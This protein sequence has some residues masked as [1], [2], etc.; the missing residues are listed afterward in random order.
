MLDKFELF[1]ELP[2][3]IRAEVTRFLSTKDFINLSM[4]SKSNSP[5]FSTNQ[6]L[7]PI[8]EARKFLHHVVCG[9]HEVVAKMLNKTPHLMC[10]RGQVRDLSGRTFTNISGFEYCMWAL[11]KHMWT[12][13]L[14]SLHKT[15]EEE[16]IKAVLW[17]QYQKIKEHGVTYTLHG[18]TKHYMPE[19]I[20]K[21]EKHFDFEGTIIKE[22]QEYVDN[23]DDNQWQ[24][25]V[26]GA[27]RLLPAH[28]VDEYCSDTGLCGRSLW[29]LP[30]FK[31]QHKSSKE[32]YS[33][34]SNR[35]EP[36]FGPVSTLGED[37][38]IYNGGGTTRAAV[39]VTFPRGGTLEDLDAI[40]VLYE[41][42]TNDFLALEND[43]KPCKLAENQYKY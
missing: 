31:E 23:R 38:A 8:Y 4:T 20:N 21:T 30:D 13:M 25:G 15:K 12:K 35:L 32:F 41:V 43:L 17:T 10:I 9:N 42:R 7:K 37:F 28:V 27:Q 5:F 39:S 22:L 26:G 34:K 18:A 19:T 16:E 24:K 33:W 14:A 36:W 11:D 29:G 3:D 40:K 6:H 1:D 2:F